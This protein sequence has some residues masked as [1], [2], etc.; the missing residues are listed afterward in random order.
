M[1]YKSDSDFRTALEERLRQRERQLQQPLVRLRKRLV[2]ERCMSRLQR[3]PDSP[4]ILKGGFALELRLGDRA[5]MTKDLDI[6][7]DLGY[8]GQAAVSPAEVVQALREALAGQ[9]ADRFV[10]TLS[11]SRQEVLPVQGATAFRFSVE[12]RLAGRRFETIRVDVGLGD[13]IIPP[14]DEL[15]GSD[16]LQFADI[17]APVI[18]TVS[19]V[20]H[21]AEKVHALTLPFDN[22][23]NT[24]VKDL[25]DIML[26]LGLGP[27]SIQ[28]ARNAV[29]AIFAARQTHE[30]PK[31][32]EMPPSTW[33]SF[34][35]A[36]AQELGIQ[37]TTLESATSRLNEYWRMLW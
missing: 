16:F 8:F 1:R 21:L 7:V 27:P 25:A 14:V 22:R 5:R 15:R 9:D 4:W 12:A 24:R 32:I 36:M 18:R 34:Y 19:R 35:T 26:L 30:I 17:P 33:V 13:P 2:F 31:A 20:Q 28:A 11:E 37:E 6:G 29:E 3:R 23:I 10:F